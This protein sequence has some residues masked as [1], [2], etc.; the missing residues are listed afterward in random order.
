MMYEDNS[1]T[2]PTPVQDIHGDGRWMS[3]HE[4]FVSEAKEREADVIFIGDSIIQQLQQNDVWNRYFEPLHSLNFGI[5]GDQTQHVLWRVQNGEMDGNSVRIVVL[6]VGTNNH[7]NTADEI[8]DAL[9]TIVK[10]I[11]ARQPE[12]HV[13]VVEIPPRGQQPNVVR[14]KLQA[15]NRLMRDRKIDNL[16]RRFQTI[17]V[18]WN[19]FID[20]KTGEISHKDMYD[21]LHFTTAGYEKLF[22]PIAEEI[23]CIL[24]E[25]GPR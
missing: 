17:C 19:L 7:E 4:R 23:Q 25:F 22:E 11:H 13:L 3:L 16:D 15:V 6:L 20:Q 18:D 12:A 10:E 14:D 24:G 1:A 9:A 21:Y 8:C 2:K 5:G